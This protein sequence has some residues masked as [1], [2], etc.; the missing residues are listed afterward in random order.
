MY[1]ALGP[2]LASHDAL[3]CPALAVPAVAA[4]HDPWDADYRINGVKAD[5]EYGWVLTHPFNMLSNC[6]VMAVPSGFAASG[7][8]TGIQIVGRTFDDARVFRAAFAYEKAVGGWFKNSKSR[9]ALP[10]SPSPRFSGG[11][12][13][14]RATPP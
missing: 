7:V 13:A 11:R 5:P 9:P 14:P 10:E 4:D 6:P 12:R 2:V 3:V 1:Q 8:P